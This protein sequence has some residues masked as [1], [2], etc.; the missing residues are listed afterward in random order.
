MV[1]ISSPPI[2]NSLDSRFSLNFKGLLEVNKLLQRV[3]QLSF[4]GYRF[5]G[6]LC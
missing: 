2:H 5:W 3:R 6:R 4:Q 1:E